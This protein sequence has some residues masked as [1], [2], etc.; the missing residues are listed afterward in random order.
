IGALMCG[1]VV[2]IGADPR[3]GEPELADLLELLGHRGPDET[4]VDP[5]GSRVRMGFKRLSII[6]VAGSHQPMRIEDG[7]LA[8]VFNGEIYNYLELRDELVRECGAV[9]DT[10]GDTEV[11]LAG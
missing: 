10:R 4:A 9:F 11:V 6:D 5:A 1:F 3:P 7:R 2:R 8:I